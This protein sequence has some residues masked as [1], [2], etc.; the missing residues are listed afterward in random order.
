MK[1]HS[2]RAD[3]LYAEEIYYV[4]CYTKLR[5]VFGWLLNDGTR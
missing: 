2:N 5:I 3:I 1:L 4:E